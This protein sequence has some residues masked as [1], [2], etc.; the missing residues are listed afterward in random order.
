MRRKESEIKGR[1]NLPPKHLKMSDKKLF[2]EI[3]RNHEKARRG[4]ISKLAKN[5]PYSDITSFQ[6]HE[7]SEGI[8]KR[9]ALFD[10]NFPAFLPHLFKGLI[11]HP[12]ISATDKDVSIIHVNL[13]DA[14]DICKDF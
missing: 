14:Y 13:L 10:G 7:L 8:C 5:T 11:N 12:N 3:D 9:M 4:L 2:E 1:I 6:V